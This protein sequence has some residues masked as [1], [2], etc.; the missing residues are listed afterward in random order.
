[1]LSAPEIDKTPIDE[2]SL[3]NLMG[4][5]LTNKLLERAETNNDAHWIA[6]HPEEYLEDGSMV[7]FKLL[8]L[9]AN[10][11]EA[12]PFVRNWPELYCADKADEP[13]LIRFLCNHEQIL[14]IA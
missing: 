8:R 10:E 12:I 1:M 4:W 14:G 3:A 6:S 2:D 11:G 9:A 13:K 5:D 7:Q